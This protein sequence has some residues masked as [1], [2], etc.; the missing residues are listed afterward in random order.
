[1]ALLNKTI[2]RYMLVAI[3]ISSSGYIVKLNGAECSLA[4]QWGASAREGRRMYRREETNKPNFMED[5]YAVYENVNGLSLFSVYD[6]HSGSGA[7]DYVR[8]H[9]H[10]NFFHKNFSEAQA[11]TIAEKLKTAFLTTDEDFLKDPQFKKDNSGTTALVA[12]VNPY[13][14]KLVVAHSGDSRGILARYIGVLFATK[15]HKP[16]LPEERKRIE[17]AEGFVDCAYGCGQIPKIYVYNE[18]NKIELMYSSPSRGSDYDPN[19]C[20]HLARV[21]GCLAMSRVLGGSQ[22]KD[23]GVIADPDICEKNIQKDDILILVSD[24]VTGV[25]SNT[26]IVKFVYERFNED[27]TDEDETDEDETDEDETDEDETDEDE[28]DEDETDEDE[29]DEDDLMEEQILK[30][31][32][33][34][35]EEVKYE[36]G[37]NT[38]VQSVA[39]ALVN[40]AYNKGSRDN[41][42]TLIV[43]FG[44]LLRAEAKK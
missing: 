17:K 25:M 4:L 11:K 24:G 18:K 2:T 32:A 38:Q 19:C 28:T 29:T 8:E 1:M 42:T 6:G 43:K 44:S 39:R 21:N 7:A 10:K 3:L 30:E 31:E 40:E 33:E 20:K 9:L 13:T 26:E 41:I 12:V 5:R 36:E 34:H 35:E 27:E 16:D 22:Y 23:D 14:H 37:N 15:D